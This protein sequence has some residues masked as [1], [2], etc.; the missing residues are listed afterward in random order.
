MRL[1][2]LEDEVEWME[3]QGQIP[4][5]ESAAP[6]PVRTP[7]TSEEKIALFMDLFGTRREVYPKRW[8]NAKTG[9]SGYSPACDNEWRPGI[10]RKPQVKCSE[11]PHQKFPRLGA[12][13]VEQHLRGIHT[14]G[15][16]A[17]ASDSTCRFLAADFDGDAR[18]D[19]VRLRVR[20]TRLPS[21]TVA[22]A[23]APS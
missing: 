19:D 15:V 9:K 5:P 3:S 17:I 20:S 11:C 18:S 12:R 10:C 7:R 8:D 21:T 14:A 1:A 16:Y 2:R 23:R 4:L 13:A 6:S 22:R